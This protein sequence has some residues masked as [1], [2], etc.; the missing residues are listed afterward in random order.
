[1]SNDYCIIHDVTGDCWQCRADA[2]ANMPPGSRNFVPVVQ[3][4]LPDE[5]SRKC[6]HRGTRLSVAPC[7][8]QMFACN[9]HKGKKCAPVGIAKEPFLSC[10]ACDDFKPVDGDVFR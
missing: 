3:E 1:M 4:E 6:L 9:L 10:S 5:D 8:G 7:C 2:I